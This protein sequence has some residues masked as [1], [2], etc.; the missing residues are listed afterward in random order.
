MSVL[1]RSKPA[2]CADHKF[3]EAEVFDD[4]LLKRLQRRL[5]IGRTVKDTEC[6][7]NAVAI[8][9]QSHLND[10]IRPVFLAFS[11][12]AKLILQFFLKVIIGA[13]I[14]ENSVIAG[15]NI[16]AVFVYFRLDIIHFTGK[17]AQSTVYVM[18]FIRGL[19]QKLHRSVE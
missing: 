10:R 2:V 11:V 14:K 18:S 13:V 7:R 4:I 12:F 5:L 19:L 8:H 16:V 15:I 1:I 6:Q 3:T 17:D 9:E